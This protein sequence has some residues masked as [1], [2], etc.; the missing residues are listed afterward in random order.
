MSDMSSETAQGAGLLDRG[1]PILIRNAHLITMDERV[2]DLLGDILVKDGKIAAVGRD[3]SCEGAAVIDGTDRV[4]IPGFVNSHIHLWQTVIKGCAGDWS[5]GEY[6][7][8]ILGAA[9]KHYG[10]EDVRVATL[11]GALEQ[12]DAGVTTVYDWSHILNTPDHADGAIDALEQS[13]IR[14]VFGHGTPGDDIARWWY[15]SREPHPQ[16]IVRIRRTRLASDEAL[17]TLGLS[18]RGP[19]YAV[20]EINRADIELARSLGIMSSMHLAAGVFGEYM[21]HCRAMGEAGLLGPDVNLTHCNRLTDDEIAMAVD[22]GA[23]ISVTPEVEMQMGHGLPVTG[24]VKA[25]G[26]R[27]TLGTDVVSSVSAD[28]FSQMRFAVQ[29]QRMLENSKSH[30]LGCML[31]RLP[32]SARDVLNYATLQGAKALGLASRIGSIT[33]AKDADLTILSWPSHHSSPLADPV[34]AVVFHA[35]LAN[36][37]TVMIAGRVQKFRHRLLRS[38][39]TER[40][41]ATQIGRRIMTAAGFQPSGRLP[42]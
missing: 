38:E 9:G 37:D 41:Q 6:L 28:M 1:R 26:G 23:S 18:L 30:A 42:T 19:D 12:I 5:F 11:L 2:G 29:A 21:P 31:E 25:A 24:R 13:G 8:Y 15:Q 32:L 35:S 3:L 34:Q 10:P 36:V 4:V 7:Q 22:M 14:A 33:P 40:H 20:P 39:L 17:V 27:V 16:D